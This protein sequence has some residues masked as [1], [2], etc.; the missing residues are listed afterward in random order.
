MPHTKFAVNE[1]ISA[2][3]SELTRCG[4]RPIG[5]EYPDIGNWYANLGLNLI[6]RDSPPQ[7]HRGFA[8]QI[9]RRTIKAITDYDL[10]VAELE[11]LVN[12]GPGGRWSPYF[13]ALANFESAV[14]HIGVAKE[15]ARKLTGTPELTYTPGDG[16]KLQRFSSIYDAIRHKSAAGNEIVSI[17]DRG[18]VEHSVTGELL[19]EVSFEEIEEL[20]EYFANTC[21]AILKYE[22]PKSVP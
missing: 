6:Y 1:F 3:A 22:A 2:R 15:L 9:F 20:L 17:S 13:K 12:D 19:Q 16:S 8:F 21:D 10:G 14:V 18:L 7:N 11:A 4:A 5:S